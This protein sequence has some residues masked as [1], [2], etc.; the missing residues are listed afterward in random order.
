ME[1]RRRARYHIRPHAALTH[2]PPRC[3]ISPHAA[4]TFRNEEQKVFA[5]PKPAWPH[6]QLEDVVANFRPSVLVGATGRTPGA[7]TEEIMRAMVQINSPHRPVVF[8]LSNPKTQ[9]EVNSTDA[10]TWTEGKVIFGSGTKFNS[11]TVDG[12][13]HHPGKSVAAGIRPTELCMSGMVN[14]VYIFPGL[15]FGAVQCGAKTISDAVFLKAA[16]AVGNA[17]TPQD[18]KE[19]RVVPPVA[20]IRS[21]ALKVAT[22]VVEQVMKDGAATKPIDGTEAE[23]AAKLERNMWIPSGVTPAELMSCEDAN[24][25]ERKTSCCLGEDEKCRP[26]GWFASTEVKPLSQ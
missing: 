13:K 21:V 19:D 14:N 22:A 20:R 17:L 3:L 11:V 24:C 7:F 2:Q 1:V 5:V 12:V 10:Y 25:R 26:S 6:Q 15:S 16:E 4:G 9:A 18:I 23:I 8:A